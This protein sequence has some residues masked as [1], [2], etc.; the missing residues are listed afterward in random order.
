MK[1]LFCAILAIF[2]SASIF[3]AT[4]NQ[5]VRSVP[6]D[7]LEKVFSQPKENLPQLVKS[8]VNGVSGESAKVKVL[9][10]WI[11]DNIAYDT[12]MYFSGR[13]SDQDYESVLKKKKGVCA[14]YTNLMSAMC[15]YAGVEAFGVMGYSKGFG[16][17]GK[18]GKQTDHAW[19]VVKIGSSWKLVD[20]TWDAGYVDW[21]TW[22]KH[23]SDEWFF[24]PPEQFIYSHLPEK[25]E[26]QYLKNPI[27]AEQFVKEPYV[28][29]KFFRYGFSLGKNIPDYT[30]IISGEAE[31]DFGLSGSGVSV[32]SL[33][34]DKNSGRNVE[35]ASWITR[36]P[37]SIAA[38]F[39]VPDKKDY[40]ALLFAKK[41]AEVRYS[42]R[43]S[44]G[45][46]E[47]QI[48]PGVEKLFAEKKI[49]KVEYEH[50]MGAF[51]KVDENGFY[52]QSEDLFATGRNNAILKIFKLLGMN[53]DYFEP[54]LDFVI[55]ADDSYDGFGSTGKYPYA[56]MNYD[57]ATNTRLVSPA[58]SSL[59]K[60]ET[61][62][63]EIVS[64]D[65]SGIGVSVAGAL[66]RLSKDPKTGAFVGELTVGDVEQVVVY[67]TKNGK[68]YSGLWFY[69]VE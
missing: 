37:S 34:H 45:Q 60:G 41:T 35:G 59:K 30:T 69:T 19:N 25:E 62:R 14:G 44:I 64:K 61:V 10:D 46:F 3:A 8:L 4:M 13:V 50:F 17:A 40:R 31:F 52:Y 28:A 26:Y 20:V 6:K 5:K 18:L 39:D 63:F 2:A 67:G 66:E 47:G 68:N 23:Y 29:G 27:S 7:I 33:I 54:V 49:T 15:Y 48:V 21:K 56:Y 24:L 22:I 1:K 16:Y 43:F 36:S 42:D 9:H 32:N 65:F 11:C 38:K 51:F 57:S 12:D 58:A 55:K 53:P